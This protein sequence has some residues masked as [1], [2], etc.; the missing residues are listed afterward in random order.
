MQK[1][2]DG[3][4]VS[5]VIA[6]QA[7]GAPLLPV[8]LLDL[9][10]IRVADLREGRLVAHADGLSID[11]PDAAGHRAGAGEKDLVRVHQLL[12][13]ERLLDHR[14]ALLTADLQDVLARNARQNHSRA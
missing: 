3:K 4:S 12:H 6:V 11:L 2:T 7:A 14:D 5:P 8:I 9:A 10:L 13:R 1:D